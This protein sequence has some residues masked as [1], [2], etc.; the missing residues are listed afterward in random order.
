MA[1]SGSG[2]IKKNAWSERR[3]ISLFSFRCHLHLHLLLKTVSEVVVVVK[4][5]LPEFFSPLFIPRVHC[6]FTFGHFSPGFQLA[7]LLIRASRPS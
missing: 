4:S 7:A 6:A 5:I 3:M 2:F 1:L